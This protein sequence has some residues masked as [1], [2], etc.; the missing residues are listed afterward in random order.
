[1]QNINKKFGLCNNEQIL[2]VEAADENTGVR[3]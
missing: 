3:R 1:M 2:T